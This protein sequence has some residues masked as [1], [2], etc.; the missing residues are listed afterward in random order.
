MTVSAES[1]HG[2]GRAEEAA[3]QSLQ[4]L[5]SLLQVMLLELRQVAALFAH[6]SHPLP[7]LL[8]QPSGLMS[9]HGHD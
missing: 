2:L 3:I 8:E 9:G 5:P 7:G 1:A 6:F 4:R